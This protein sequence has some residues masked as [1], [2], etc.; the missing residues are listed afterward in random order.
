MGQK[1]PY[2]AEIEYL[3]STGTQHI[4]FGNDSMQMTEYKINL[5][6][7]PTYIGGTSYGSS[8]GGIM[9]LDGA[10]QIGWYQKGWTVGNAGS[11]VP[12]IPVVGNIYN[13]EYSK[14]LDGSYWVDGVY[15]GL[16]RLGRMPKRIFIIGGAI[17]RSK[18]KLFGLKI[19]N[20][21]DVVVY[22]F[23][24]VRIGT[25]GYLYDK[26]SSQ[27]FGNTGTGEFILGADK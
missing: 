8:Y 13:I 1:L 22:D 21:N 7:S 5:T 26:V 15:T 25:T 14:N 10:P 20:S 18:C 11:Q 27:L 4:V 17:S 3:E 19:L 24:P 9:G 23:I 6:V 12:Y 16:K 2:D